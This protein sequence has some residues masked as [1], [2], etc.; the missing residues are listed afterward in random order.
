MDEPLLMDLMDFGPSENLMQVQ[1]EPAARNEVGKKKSP[2]KKLPPPPPSFM[3]MDG[4]SSSSTSAAQNV[5]NAFMETKKPAAPKKRMPFY[6]LLAGEQSNDGQTGGAKVEPRK[7]KH[8]LSHF[9][10]DEF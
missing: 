2:E 3:D 1:D 10:D 4:P 6:E 5:M 9:W 8:L 7:M